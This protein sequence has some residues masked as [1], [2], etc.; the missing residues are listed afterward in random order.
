MFIAMI[1]G[2]LNLRYFYSSFTNIYSFLILIG[3]RRLTVRIVRRVLEA[4][5]TLLTSSAM[6]QCRDSS[7]RNTAWHIH[8]ALA[9]V[10]T[11]KHVKEVPTSLLFVRVY[12]LVYSMNQQNC[13][14][15]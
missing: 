3:S 8:G 10:S 14:F 7:R 2:C 13:P 9:V 11:Q 5:L 4:L 6:R 1:T 15:Q 12:L